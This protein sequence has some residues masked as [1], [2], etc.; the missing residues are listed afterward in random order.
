L[1]GAVVGDVG[2]AEVGRRVD[3]PLVDILK[4]G[5]VVVGSVRTL[6]T[7]IRL[8]LGRGRDQ[9]D[10]RGGGRFVEP[11]EGDGVEEG[12]LVWVIEAFGEVMGAGALD[13]VDEGSVRGINVGRGGIGTVWVHV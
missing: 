13:I 7:A 5:V 10:T 1:I 2:D 9:G 4:L 6:V 12:P 11:L 8:E 3:R